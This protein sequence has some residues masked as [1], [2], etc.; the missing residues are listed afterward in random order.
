M[1]KP[2]KMYRW[3]VQFEVSETWVEDG[4]DLTDDRAHAML[5]NDLRHA[6]GH[7]LRAKILKAPNARAIR[8]AQGEKE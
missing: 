7:E 4:F 5:A 2:R 6:Y 3:V 1:F 8:V